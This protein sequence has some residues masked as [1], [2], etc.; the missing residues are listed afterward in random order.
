VLTGSF[1]R[2]GRV[3][4]DRQRHGNRNSFLGSGFG[5]FQSYRPMTRQAVTPG[6]GLYAC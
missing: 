2:A 6:W 4:G 5:Q 3:P 1:Q